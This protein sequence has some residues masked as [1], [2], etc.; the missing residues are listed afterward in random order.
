MT[1]KNLKMKGDRLISE[2]VKIVDYEC[3]CCGTLTD[4]HTGHFISRS[5]YGTRWD[6][7]NCHLQCDRCNSRHEWDEGPMTLFMES[8]KYSLE[9]LRRRSRLSIKRVS[10]E[11]IIGSME[12]FL[13]LVESGVIFSRKEAERRLE[14]VCII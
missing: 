5:F 8:E 7:S 4:L 3:C 9:D 14:G 1:Y 12:D 11:I 13:R 6:L 10:L 2:I